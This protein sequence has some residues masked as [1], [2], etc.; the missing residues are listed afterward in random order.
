MTRK[1]DPWLRKRQIFSRLPVSLKKEKKKRLLWRV[2]P[3]LWVAFKRTS[4]VIGASVIIASFV[5]FWVLSSVFYEMNASS[6]IARLPSQ[7]VLYLEID[8]D[9]PDLVTEAD[10]SQPFK[11][12]VRTLGNYIDALDRA[13]LDPR[14]SGV[15]T[16]ITGGSLS[17][18]H[19]QEFRSALKEFKE[20]GKFAY[21][22]AP[23]FDQGLSGYYLASA[24]DEVWMQPLGVVTILGISAQI[25]Y[26]RGVL[27]EVGIK[28][29]IY[30][31]KE[32]KGAYDT[33]IEREMPDA[34]RRT[35][36][37]LV[38][39]IASVISEDI[40][41]D[42]DITAGEFKSLVDRG[43]YIDTEALDAGLIDV[44]DYEDVLIE[45]MNEQVTGDPDGEDLR[46]V[47]FD[48]Y[49]TEMLK[50]RG[51][52]RPDYLLADF[53][54]PVVNEAQAGE[55]APEASEEALVETGDTKAQDEEVQEDDLQA[56][57]EDEPLDAEVETAQGF[58]GSAGGSE[59]RV[60]DGNSGVLIGK[61]SGKPRIAL[62]YA[63]GAI[64]DSH[65]VQAFGE[66]VSFGGDGIVAADELSGV[67]L[68]VAEDDLYDA[69]VLRIDSPGGAPVAS[70]T[71]LRALQKVQEEGKLVIVS[72][73]NVAASGGYW[74]AS[75]A[76]QIFVLPSTITGSIGVLGGKFSLK[77]L[78]E[79]LGV[80]WDEVRWGEKASMWS[81]NQ[82]YDANEEQRVNAMLDRIYSSFV[83]RVAKGR[84]LSE[85][86]VEDVARGRV[87]S[88][89]RAVEVGLADQIGGLSD[90]LDYAARQVGGYDRH[91]VDVQI[92]PR[93]LTPVEQLV[94]FL[95]EQGSAG[96]ALRIQAGLFRSVLPQIR[97]VFL[98]QSMTGAP[99]GSVYE[100]VR[101][102][103]R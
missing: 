73:G 23:S 45:T 70:E 27:D 103:V 11:S 60:G 49:V 15:Y 79:K 33:V 20:S 13:A 56:Q 25:P 50:G 84:D 91:S 34:S 57:E 62:V 87:W 28:P 12:N 38:E 17:I 64:L 69:V 101:L 4:T 42:L 97:D 32:Y 30:K 44:L 14:V 10:F 18:A 96:D 99:G 86:E 98:Y 66:Q 36:T 59:Q 1:N 43:L 39:D 78:W 52:R 48:S 37:R 29:Q 65:N 46:Y 94:K 82:P 26:V 5:S 92:V 68:A 31:R 54:S 88:G 9:I 2:F 21:V 35:M 41:K 24:F 80:N 71:I 102:Q 90:A 58:A 100:P 81:F 7:M 19:A 22:Y 93:P 3:I 85:A 8:G 74:I 51:F 72:M 83:T 61:P 89:K 75:S 55:D 40:A 95:E 77:G 63:L 76:D 16:K 53:V 67:L 6:D 47:R